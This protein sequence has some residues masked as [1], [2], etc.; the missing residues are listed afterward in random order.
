[1]KNFKKISMFIVCMSLF[2]LSSLIFT[3]CGKNDETCKLYVF[4]QQGGCVK[5]DKQEQVVEFGDEGSK[6]F[7]YDK[8][9]TITLN[10]IADEG[11]C[12][13]KWLFTD[14]LADKY[15]DLMYDS[16]CEIVIN[17]EK[18]VVKAIFAVDDSIT[19]NVQYSTGTGY[20]IELLSGYSNTVT[21]GN[22]F[23]FK[24]NLLE[25]YNNSEITVKVNGKTI[26]SNAEGV[27]SISNINRDI[28]I[29]VEG[30]VK[31]EETVEYETYVLN[32]DLEENVKSL[33][34]DILTYIPST[35]SI[36]I[37]KNAEKLEEYTASTF[38]VTTNQNLKISIKTLIDNINNYLEENPS[39][40]TSVNYLQ[41]NDTEF[42]K[43][44]ED[45]MSIDWALLTSNN[46]N[47]I[48]VLK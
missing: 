11:Y 17:D 10:A 23:K 5:V 35:I 33:I 2:V 13:V 15:E 6:Y 34:P 38:M 21:L 27:Y 30:V 31:N 9:T 26:T 22:D 20:T 25:D 39:V 44:V 12:F 36:S 37:A 48:I 4:A 41:I 46:C 18:V 32:L 19:Y 47:V 45:A 8:N 43:V 28:N 3:G 16:E 40:Y 42:I 1:M 24:V 7:V 14:D 29:S